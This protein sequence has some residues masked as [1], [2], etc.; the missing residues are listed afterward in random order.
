MFS[1]TFS[2]SSSQ[3]FTYTFMKHIPLERYTNSKEYAELIRSLVHASVLETAEN[4]VEK[5]LT[6]QERLNTALGGRVLA[7][8]NSSG[9]LV[10]RL[11]DG[12][13][14]EMEIDMGKLP[15]TFEGLPVKR[16]CDFSYV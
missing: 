10:L 7:A 8:N 2:T 15:S 9:G 13:G 4:R 5:M 6:A 12:L 3:F 16:I 11:N 14:S 1:Q